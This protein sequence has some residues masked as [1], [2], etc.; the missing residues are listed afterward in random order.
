MNLF[1]KAVLALL[2]YQAV[3]Y[4]EDNFARAGAFA[5]RL[6]SDLLRERIDETMYRMIDV[7]PW[8][9]GC[10]LYTSRCV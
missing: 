6:G 4:L 3:N 10:L 5:D 9:G 8:Y 7:V 1:G 2:F